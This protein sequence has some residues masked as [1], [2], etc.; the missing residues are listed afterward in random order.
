MQVS[1]R[2]GNTMPNAVQATNE[3]FVDYLRTHMFGLVAFVER[4]KDSELF[5]MASGVIIESEGC[6]VLLT[7]AHFLRDVKR[8]KKQKRLRSLLLMVHHESGLCTPIDLNLNKNICSFSEDFDFGY[9][10][11]DLDVVA[12]A[13]KRGGHLTRRDNLAVW[14]GDLVNF[15]VVG[16]ASAFC[17][18]R[19]EVIATQ[20]RGSERVAWTL[21]RPGDLA[22]VTSR[23]LFEGEGTHR[24]TYRFAL[25][26]GYRDYSGTSGGPI[27][28]YTKGALVRDYDLVG[29]QSMQFRV[30]Q[31]K[32][33]HLIAVS[34]ALAVELVDDNVRTMKESV[35]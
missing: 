14:S 15:F 22:V 33:T 35:S 26:N 25:V 10:L 6:F 2:R 5:P 11:L 32:P 9:V 27:F 16:H 7:A 30:D 19:K 13:G 29:I 4:P 12:E 18:L 31:Q 24:G 21:T 8:W 17:K 28:G 1:D 23:V 34:A 20:K 3:Q